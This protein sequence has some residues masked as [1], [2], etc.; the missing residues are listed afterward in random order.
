[1]SEFRSMRLL[2]FPKG[3]Y[4][5]RHRC[6]RG[7]PSFASECWHTRHFWQKN[8]LYALDPLGRMRL[9]PARL[10]LQ[11]RDARR[12]NLELDWH[13]DHSEVVPGCQRAQEWLG[14]TSCA[15]GTGLERKA[16]STCPSTPAIKTSSRCGSAAEACHLPQPVSHGSA[17]H[18]QWLIH[19]RRSTFIPAASASWTQGLCQSQPNSGAAPRFLL[20]LLRRARSSRL[21]PKDPAQHP[22]TR[23][24][25]HGTTALAIHLSSDQHAQPQFP[26][27]SCRLDPELSL[28]DPV[29]QSDSSGRANPRGAGFSFETAESTIRRAAIPD[30]NASSSV[31]A[32]G[33]GGLR[34]QL[35]PRQ[36]G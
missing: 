18:Y 1:M 17:A 3:C 23:A 19:W 6:Q 34:H 27:P 22:A 7:S 29:L 26:K 2:I 4:R 10:P 12:A 28:P 14:W 20:L 24:V 33:R 15:C 5:C 9:Y 30:A 32:G 16:C 31:R 35:C 36:R 21:R 8:I 25:I 11:A 13:P